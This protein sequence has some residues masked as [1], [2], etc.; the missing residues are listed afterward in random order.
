MKIF[1]NKARKLI[2]LQIVCQGYQTCYVSLEETTMAEVKAM[3][4]KVILAQNLS[5][6]YKGK[7]TA[8]NIRETLEN[9]KGK[10]GKSVSVSFCGLIPIAVKELVVAHVE[11]L[12]P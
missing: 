3:V 11:H 7:R 4:E 10:N 9:E 6:F 2:R 5:P 12:Q 1:E 8:V